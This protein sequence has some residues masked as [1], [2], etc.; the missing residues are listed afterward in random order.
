MSETTSVMDG[1]VKERISGIFGKSITNKVEDRL[2]EKFGISLSQGIEEYEKLDFVFRE[3]FGKGADGIKEK[4]LKQHVKEKT[5]SNQSWVTINDQNVCSIILKAFG[6]PEKKSI[7]ESAFEPKI[8]SQI[9]SECHLPQTSGYRKINELMDQG[10]LVKKGTIDHR[11]KKINC[12][13]TVFSD[14]DIKMDVKSRGM[15]VKAK[16][17]VTEKNNPILN[18]IS[19]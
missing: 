17:N 19:Y 11:S 9:I 4:I 7:L 14:L 18:V 2:F 6:D 13:C 3:F 10:L 12:Y 8:V 16:L 15:T 1:T 5:N